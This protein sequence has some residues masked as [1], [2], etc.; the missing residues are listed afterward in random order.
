MN[1]WRPKWT[2]LL[3]AGVWVL[4][5]R[6]AMAQRPRF[7]VSAP[8]PIGAGSDSLP[9]A[10]ALGDLNKDG[11][12]DIVVVTVD[13]NDG[14]IAVLINNGDGTFGAPRIIVDEEGVVGDPVAVAIADFGS[15]TGGPDT[16]NDIVIIDGDGGFTITFG[17]GAGNFV[18]DGTL[19][20]LDG[21]DFPVAVAVGDFDEQ[22]GPDVAVLDQDGTDENG[23]VY[24]FC[25]IG[26]AGVLEPC[27]TGSL[28]SGGEEPIDIGAGD[29][30]GDG[31]VDVV[32]LN[33]GADE[34]DGTVGLLTGNGD[35]TF[36]IPRVA[37]FGVDN[38]PRDLAVGSLNPDTDSIDDV[39]VGEFE[40]LSNDNVTILLGGTTGG[41]FTERKSL[42]EVATTAIAIGNL[43]GDTN[44]DL[45]GANDPGQVSSGITVAVGDGAGD[46]ADPQSGGSLS[47][48]AVSLV[49]GRLN[50]DELDDLVALNLD[51][52]ELRIAINNPTGPTDT[53]GTP[54]T[55]GE[56][57]PTPTPTPTR[58]VTP[59]LKG[60]T[61]NVSSTSRPMGLAGG[62]F[63]GD[64]TPDF[65]VLDGNGQV[66]VYLP[67]QS[68]VTGPFRT[69][70]E[71]AN[72]RP[73]S[74]SGSPTSIV[75][76]DL[77]RDSRL[78]L[79]VGTSAGVKILIASTSQRGQFNEAVTILDSVNV[80]SVAV[81]LLNE[82]SAPDL[83]VAGNDRVQIV[84]GNGDGITFT[85]RAPVAFD[86]TGAAIVVAADLNVDGWPD[87]GVASDGATNQ[88]R[89]LLQQP[90]APGNFPNQ[91]VQANILTLSNGA[92]TSMIAAVLVANGAP[93]LIV[94]MRAPDT[95]IGTFAV[96][97]RSGVNNFTLGGTLPTN[98]RPSALSTGDFVPSTGLT[99]LLVASSA[100]GAVEFF[101]GNSDGTFAPAISESEVGTQPLALLT[102]DF[103]GD[104]MDDVAVA[105]SVGGT[106]TLLLSTNVDPTPTPTATPIVTPSRTPTMTGS[107]GPSATATRGTPGPTSTPKEGAFELSSCSIAAGGSVGWTSGILWLGAGLM[108]WV[109]RRMKGRS[110]Q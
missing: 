30:N 2:F 89:I 45:G 20:E 8:I 94:T 5:P 40:V 48:G 67:E 31:N 62:D 84:F 39:A 66:I 28:S 27:A 19:T 18:I 33:Q 47:G 105:N 68:E 82:G 92:P 50:D 17:D 51:G 12:P 87:L 26:Q 15:A 96:V 41:I 99:D 37:T 44:P 43:G 6:S 104:G 70:C 100:E 79:V 78:D 107:P 77:N 108:F 52:D 91:P 63:N 59:A 80:R 38:E 14:P 85:Q 55:P 110:Q 56:G 35:G 98:G 75:S 74:I 7:N 64:G 32:V 9:Q 23:Q 101:P 95:G 102:A 21:L 58:V 42:L 3:L 13:E 10:V 73:Y 22:N 109:R 72:F 49:A 76:A 34:G 90:S 81:A 71:I 93:Q 29:F 25:N 88:L 83:A 36:T 24:F 46:F 97:R 69:M 54:G 57:T 86:I 106:L 61:V 1:C 4:L 16:N 11:R 60:C 65:A 53:P 103:D